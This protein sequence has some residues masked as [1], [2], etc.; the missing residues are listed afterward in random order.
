MKKMKK[1]C[2]RE[3]QGSVKKSFVVAVWVCK[4][5]AVCWGCVEG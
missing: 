1:E 4:R 3:R 2:S 5:R